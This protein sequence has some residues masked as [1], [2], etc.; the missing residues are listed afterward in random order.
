VTDLKQRI[1]DDT[2]EAMRARE[3]ERVAVLRM[4]LAAIKQKEVDSRTELDDT[5]VLAVLE[6]MARQ[7]Q[8]SIEQFEKAGRNDLV[9]KERFELDVVRT[10][11]PEP[12]DEAEIARIIDETVAE[13][14]AAS[15]K[16]M[17]KVMAAIK[18][19]LQGR[20]DMS[21]VSA[22]VRARLGA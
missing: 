13:T 17:G 20:A 16:D 6:K 21:A 19:R 10:Y 11:L 5:G 3:K 22:R 15:V 2:R 12:L 7:H 8:D 14:G 9:E 4:I 1:N 18:P